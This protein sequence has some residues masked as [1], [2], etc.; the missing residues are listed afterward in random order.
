MRRNYNYALQLSLTTLRLSLLHFFLTL[1]VHCHTL[2]CVCLE[3]GSLSS[4]ESTFNLAYNQFNEVTL[5]IRH[6]Q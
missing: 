2:S 6:R 4:L 5:K 3:V 1:C